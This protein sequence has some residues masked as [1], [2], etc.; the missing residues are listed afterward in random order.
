VILLIHGAGAGAWEW[1]IWQRAFAAERLSAF[2]MNLHASS[3]GLMHTRYEDYLQQV[4]AAIARHQ[5]NVVIGASLGG[6][7]AA[8]ALSEHSSSAKL[9]L[10]A[11]PGKRIRIEPLLQSQ[12]AHSQTAAPQPKPIKRWANDP[13]LCRTA[14]ALP[15]ADAASVYFAHSRWRDE[16]AFVL[17]QAI[18]GRPF[19]W[20]ARRSLMIA[21]EDD[22]DVD[23]QNLRQWAR[24]AGMEYWLIPDASHAGLLLGQR[25]GGLAQKVI[26]WLNA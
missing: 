7:L 22:V 24:A 13:Q 2:A 11:P 21:A 9:V 3:A 5:P 12:K 19:G 17:A 23:N 16:S 20:R 8:E 26:R 6:L 18:A 25:A 15:D 14:H 4:G 10:L 1:G